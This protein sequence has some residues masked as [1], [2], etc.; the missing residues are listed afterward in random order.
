MVID[1]LHRELQARLDEVLDE[2][3][4][5]R[6]AIKALGSAN[7]A[8]RAPRSARR[9]AKATGAGGAI[10]VKTAAT[11]SRTRRGAPSGASKRAERG[12]TAAPAAG[13]A[14]RGTK[15]AVLAALATG[16]AMTAGEV[17]AATGLG[18]ASVSTTLTKLARS[19]AAVK[20]D[21]GYRLASKR[22][23]RG[24]KPKAA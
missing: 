14:R 9:G 16:G 5:L 12:S 20:A 15:D 18:R 21:R 3:E 19:G 1:D 13:V 8:G 17:A 10:A 6:A 4:R 22:G 23:A 7:G 11:E 2:A 24:A